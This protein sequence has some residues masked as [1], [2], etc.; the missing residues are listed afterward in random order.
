MLKLETNHRPTCLTL[1]ALLSL[2]IAAW[3]GLRSVQSI[4]FW[5]ILKEYQAAPGPLVGTIS[6]AGWFLIGV[7]ITWGLWHGKSWAWFSALG[8]ALGYG[9]WYWFDRLIL[10][11]THSNW[12]FALVI[13]IISLSFLSVLFRRGTILFF[14]QKSPSSFLFFRS[15]LA[16]MSNASNKNNK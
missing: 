11:G 13:T 6:G 4:I 16:S 14:L 1:L 7:S 5:S 10:Q 12:L 15:L 9:F 8:G 3:N 2:A